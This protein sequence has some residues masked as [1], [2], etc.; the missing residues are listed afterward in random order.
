MIDPK[1]EWIFRREHIQSKSYNSPI[2]GK[3]L[4]GKVLITI[5]KGFVSNC[6]LTSKS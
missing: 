6:K 2:V 4:K 5:N 3:K 1:I